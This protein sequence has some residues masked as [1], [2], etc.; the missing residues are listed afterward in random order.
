[1]D[2]FHRFTRF[3][4]RT[5]NF[6]CYLIKVFHQAQQSF[7]ESQRR[8]YKVQP[9]YIP[10]PFLW[11]H[12]F[13]QGFQFIL[14]AF[15]FS[16]DCNFFWMLL[17]SL[18]YEKLSCQKWEFHLDK[19]CDL[20]IHFII[21]QGVFQL[22]ER[23]DPANYSILKNG[24]LWNLWR[25]RWRW[26]STSRWGKDVGSPEEEFDQAGQVV[27]IGHFF[28]LL[29][30]LLFH[31]HPNN[32]IILSIVS[33]QSMKSLYWQVY[34]QYCS[35]YLS[36]KSWAKTALKG[37]FV[38]LLVG[39]HYLQDLPVLPHIALWRPAFNFMPTQYTPTHQ[40][41]YLVLPTI[42]NTLKE[43]S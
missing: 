18:K 29:Q 38:C 21:E 16:L 24:L 37:Y 23:K 11:L 42:E 36:Q 6:I 15:S 28:K 27:H 32:N 8:V 19:V 35:I 9:K 33:I 30:M 41:I 34:M 2:L 22:P 13:K 3:P 7:P 1:M 43:Q 12:A 10:S 17:I 25:W 39:H 14:S 5:S 26:Q 40:L 4:W 31:V 20:L